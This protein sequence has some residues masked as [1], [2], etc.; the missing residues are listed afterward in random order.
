MGG[1]SGISVADLENGV[2]LVPGMKK[3]LRTLVKTPSEAL[4][5]EKLPQF[6]E[7]RM[8]RTGSIMLFLLILVSI[9]SGCGSGYVDWSTEP[10][11]H[12]SKVYRQCYVLKQD[13]FVLHY[14]NVFGGDSDKYPYSLM[15]PAGEDP[16]ASGPKSIDEFKSKPMSYWKASG[17][18]DASI[19]AIMPKGTHLSIDHLIAETQES[20]TSIP[21]VTIL[22]GPYKGKMMGAY[23]LL[24]DPNW[25]TVKNPEA[26][27]VMGAF[28]APDAARP[29]PRL[30]L[31]PWL[32]REACT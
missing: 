17:S 28:G 18:E 9:V 30:D 31:S 10:R 3:I 2:W 20:G 16:S 32:E 12:F 19:E 14:T 27:L 15:V 11:A 23:S 1:E 7:P 8:L 29:S 13:I 21:F 24:M 26:P 5:N 25:P 22:D 4:A 6:K